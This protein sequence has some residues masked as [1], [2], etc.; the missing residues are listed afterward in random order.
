MTTSPILLPILACASIQ[1]M[2][3]SWRGD[4]ATVTTRANGTDPVTAECKITQ[5]DFNA[6]A[7][8][9][10]I[11]RCLVD[12]CSDGASLGCETEELRV[13]GNDIFGKDIES[14]KDKRVGSC[15]GGVIGFEL[16][17]SP[18]S[19]VDWVIDARAAKPTLQATYSFWNEGTVTI[20]P[21]KLS[22]VPAA[23]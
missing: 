16:Y 5:M 20:N 6:T 1:T 12:S 22:R 10:K 4:V 3:G 23:E 11:E 17:S 18:T 15:A 19:W 21:V 2:N 9:F 13:S 14:G 8:G 7:A